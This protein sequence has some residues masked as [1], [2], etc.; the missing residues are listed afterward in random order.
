[1]PSSRTGT[2]ARSPALGMYGR[3]MTE[4]ARLA[5]EL[6]AIES[7]NPTLVPGGPGEA[8]IA[9][10]IASWLERA[11]LQVSLQDAG[12]GRI[13]V[14]GVARGSGGGRTLLLTGHIDTVAFADGQPREPRVEGGRLYGRGAYDMKGGV[15]AVMMA[16]A[17]VGRLAGD[18]M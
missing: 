15:A 1:A 8:P 14:V 4:L 18:V 13:N 6:V 17:S 12:A 2:A 10:N 7:V 3:A 16:A 11:G 9:R 5:E